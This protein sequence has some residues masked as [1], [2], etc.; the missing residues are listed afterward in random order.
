MNKN[1]STR[2]LSFYP[3]PTLGEPF[4]LTER[5]MKEIEAW[6]SKTWSD[7]RFDTGLVAPSPDIHLDGS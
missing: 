6:K 7:S 5:A 3:T 2:N 1:G 4:T